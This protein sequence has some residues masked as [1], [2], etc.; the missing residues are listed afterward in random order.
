LNVRSALTI[1]ALAAVAFGT[2]YVSSSLT[3]RE[4]IDTSADRPSAGFYVRAARFL[5]TDLDGSLLYEVEAEFAEQQPNKEIELQDVKVTYTTE[6]DVPWTITA[7]EATLSRPR[8]TLQLR[9]HVIATSDEGFAGEV[10]EIRSPIL[11]IE[12]NSYRAETDS[13][14]QL[15]IGSRS[16]TGTGMLALLQQNRLEL[17]SNVSGKF[18]P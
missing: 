9:G 17:K 12:P 18:V 11:E 5:G 4:V 13:R 2:W 10:T 15:R 3:D 14:V 16:L 7:D 1:V 6:A 8:G